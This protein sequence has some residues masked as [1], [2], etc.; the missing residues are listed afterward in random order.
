MRVGASHC[1]AS[2]AINSVARQAL[3]IL[4]PAALTL[5]LYAVLVYV[6]TPG[7]IL[8][9]EGLELGTTDE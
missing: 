7:Y 6:V 3:A 2:G 9:S 4:L 8:T 5:V 1:I